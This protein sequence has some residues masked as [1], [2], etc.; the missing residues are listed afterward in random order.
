MTSHLPVLGWLWGCACCSLKWST[1]H[2]GRIPLPALEVWAPRTSRVELH[3]ESLGWEIQRLVV[4]WR[5]PVSWKLINLGSNQPELFF[6]LFLMFFDHRFCRG[7]MVLPTFCNLGIFLPLSSVLWPYG[8]VWVPLEAWQPLSP[9]RVCQAPHP[10][11]VP[12][13]RSSLVIQGHHC[14]ATYILYNSYF[15]FT[16]CLLTC[17]KSIK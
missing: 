2:W 6:I 14:S 17:R 4:N 15:L 11:G 5:V 1:P 10:L 16:L 7:R 8:A 3:L 12:K 13:R 9:P